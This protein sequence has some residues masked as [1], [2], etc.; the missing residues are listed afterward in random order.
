MGA[1]VRKRQRMWGFLCALLLPMATVSTGDAAAEGVTPVVVTMLGPGSVRVRVAQG[2]TFPCD[3]A[4]NRRLIAGKFKPGQVLRTATPD[5]CVCVQQT[6]EPFSDTDWSA[7]SMVCRP[8]I[9]TR[10]NRCV[11]VSDPTIRLQISSKRP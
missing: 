2:T 5:R 3:S 7:S 8:Q 6:Y 4:D 1:V 9:C 11:P 10:P